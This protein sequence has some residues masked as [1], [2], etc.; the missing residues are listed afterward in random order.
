MDY[1]KKLRDDYVNQT[2]LDISNLENVKIE[3]FN[4]SRNKYEKA[5]IMLIKEYESSR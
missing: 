4:E 2:S 3:K 1:Y 5:N